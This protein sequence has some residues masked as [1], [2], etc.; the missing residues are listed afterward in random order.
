MFN[1]LSAQDVINL[2][3]G[4][5]GHNISKLI[6]IRDS[7]GSN[8][9][10][11]DIGVEGGKSSRILLDDAIAKNNYV[12]GIDPIRDPGISDILQNPNYIFL[13]KDSVV[14]GRDW[15]FARPNIVFVDSI[16]AKEQVM[17]EL[18]YWWDLLNVNGWVV[19]HDTQW[20]GYIHKA[21]HSCAGK[22]PGNSGLGY[23][24]YAGVAWATPDKAVKEFFKLE[25]LDYEDEFIKSIHMPDSL[26]MTFIHKKKDKDFKALTEN[27]EEIESNR[28]KLLACFV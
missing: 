7:F 8:N 18:R 22:K 14:S 19:F 21:N 24:F 15:S 10:F 6:E 12:C 17:M 5:L 27:W 26:G 28:Q 25:S 16:H 20:E 9:F 1:K 2:K 13:Q 23:D 3:D 4:E 11:V